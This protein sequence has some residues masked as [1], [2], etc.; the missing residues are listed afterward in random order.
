MGL[1]TKVLARLPRS[2]VAAVTTARQ[3]YPAVDRCV[4]LVTGMMRGRDSYIGAG[5][6]RGLRFN[7]GRSAA[8]YVLGIV[9]PE[10]Q[11]V[12]TKLLHPGMTFYDIGAN[13]GFYSIIAAN[14]VGPKGRVV[15]FEPLPENVQA[16][17]H[18]VDINHFAQVTVCEMALSVTDGELSFAKSHRMTDGRLETVERLP[19]EY[20]GHIRVATRRLDSIVGE[21]RLPPPHL[22]KIDVEGA[23]NDVLCGAFST[24][25]DAR[26]V[27][28]IELHGTNAAVVRTL[29]QAGYCAATLHPYPSITE[30]HWNAAIVAVPSEKP[31]LLQTIIG[32]RPVSVSSQEAA[33]AASRLPGSGKVRF[34]PLS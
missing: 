26:P 7:P 15:S 28:I 3:H 8:S 6:G 11:L 5:A 13:V 4:G 32:E 17:K 10:T 21:A 1:L 31:E 30:A 23:E 12:F 27:L 34:T 33:S 2:W 22:V 16:L 18:N 14:L 19:S 20:S 29:A 9:E 24:L 25:A